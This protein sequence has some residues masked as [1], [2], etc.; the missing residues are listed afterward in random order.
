MKEKI[1][2]L[3]LEDDPL[4][5]ELNREQILLLEDYECTVD[6]IHDRE[7]Y[8]KSLETEPLPDLILCDYNLPQYTGVEALKELNSRDIL[9]PFIFVTGAMP[10]EV[11][12][13][14]IKAGAW[15][16][17]VK[18]RLFRL[19]LAIR[20][21]MQLK[22]EKE[23][24]REA[25]LLNERLLNA[26]E[27]TQ[28]QIILMDIDGRIEYA[29]KNYLSYIGMSKED[30]YGRKLMELYEERGRIADLESIRNEFQET[31]SFS[32][33][34]YYLEN[35]GS[36]H[37][38]LLSLNP[39][40]IKGKTCS[41]VVV[42]E[43]ITDQKRVEQELQQSNE[44]YQQLNKELIESLHN[45][46]RINKELEVSKA[47]A[48]ESDQLKTAFL[49]NLSHEI[50]TPM[51][52]ILGFA[53]LLKAGNINANIQQ[54]YLDVI[55]QSGKRM[56]KLITDLVDISKI[57]SNQLE[58]HN[59]E[60]ELNGLLD[61]IYL[62][63]KHL[64]DKKNIRLCITREFEGDLYVVLDSTKLEQVLSNLF[65]NALKFTT[66]GKICLQCRIEGDLLEF[67]IKDTG[68]GIPEDKLGIIF[69]RFMQIDNTVL[70]AAE[71]SRLGL[72]IS[73]AFVELMGGSIRVISEVGKGSEFVFTIPY[74]P[75]RQIQDDIEPEQEI[76]FD[77]G[78]TVLVAEDDDIGVMYLTE[79]L[80][81]YKFIILVARNG[82]EAVR[83]FEDHPEIS[84]VLMD[85][86]MPEMGGLEAI[87]KIR[88]MNR[89]VPIL[90]QTAYASAKDKMEAF[91][92]GCNDF[93]TKPILK[94]ELLYKMMKYL[95]V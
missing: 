33:E 88:A 66:E 57:E 26:I 93:V 4:D 85:I 87:M 65:D 38:E 54:E 45:I 42:K 58:L 74:V 95:P 17:V 44:R 31:G 59:Q 49:A 84:I 9:V 41:Y 80:H 21:A 8:I 34:I 20:G 53:G 1:H 2:I 50:R 79:I 75:A 56:L 24:A 40:C 35:D 73:R 82:V 62:F 48:E 10:E 89:E 63:F 43:E 13:D 36:E 3:M 46:E 30:I 71:G 91:E 22:K 23:S 5:A 76:L 77:E 39:V 18:D 11:A 14:A 51:N 29:N 32:G 72:S 61:R 81:Q 68:E 52:G 64:A 83:L 70:K 7:R 25:E 86:R 16:Y 94:E 27:E 90:A 69:E 19:P 60:T 15:D 78:L 92:A 28:A 55:E 37:W 47:K 67:R 12:A 6:L